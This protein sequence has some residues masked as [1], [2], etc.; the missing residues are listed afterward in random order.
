MYGM[1]TNGFRY[2]IARVVARNEIYAA[3]SRNYILRVVGPIFYFAR[4]IRVPHRAAA[5][6]A[7]KTDWLRCSDMKFRSKKLIFFKINVD[8][9]EIN[10]LLRRVIRAIFYVFSAVYVNNVPNFLTVID[11][12]FHPFS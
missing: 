12:T 6:R 9:L 2:V 7:I 10:L 8:K 11:Y 5:G 3:V 4:V 1:L